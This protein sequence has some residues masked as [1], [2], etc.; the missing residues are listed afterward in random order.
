MKLKED[1]FHKENILNEKIEK[2]SRK[3]APNKFYQD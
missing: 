2:F 3:E 1:F